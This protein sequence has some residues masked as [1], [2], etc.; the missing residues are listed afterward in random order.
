[1]RIRMLIA[2]LRA[3]DPRRPAVSEHAQDPHQQSS[4]FSS[5][6][7]VGGIVV[8]RSVPPLIF[9]QRL[10]RLQDSLHQAYVLAV[11]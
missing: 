4:K 8:P 2:P 7:C 1:M 9:D 3:W 11:Q 10:Q 5:R 6:Y